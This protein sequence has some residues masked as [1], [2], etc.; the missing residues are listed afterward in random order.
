MALHYIELTNHINTSE[1]IYVPF[2]VRAESKVQSILPEIKYFCADG[3]K[4]LEELYKPLLAALLIIR[5]DS[6]VF[7]FIVDMIDKNKGLDDYLLN[8]LATETVLLIHSFIFAGRFYFSQE[9][10]S[11]L[12]VSLQTVNTCTVFVLRSRKYLGEGKKECC[13]I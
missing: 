3:S 9:L 2:S 7:T 6:E 11:S 13:L 1:M 10:C 8:Y 12:H 5:D 4:Y